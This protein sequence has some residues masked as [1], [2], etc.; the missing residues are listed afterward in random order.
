MFLTRSI[1]SLTSSFVVKMLTV[2]YLI[3]RYF[4]LLK[5]KIVSSF[6]KCKSYSHFFFSAKILAYML[7]L[8]APYPSKIGIFYP[9]KI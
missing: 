9:R 2:Q 8:K 4:F 5:K 6:C 1:V 7:Y 3:H